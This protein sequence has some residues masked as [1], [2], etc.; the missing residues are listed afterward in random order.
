MSRPCIKCGAQNAIEA[1]FCRSCGNSF[2]ADITL[3]S[4]PTAPPQPSPLARTDSA[5]VCAKCGKENRAGTKFCRGCG[6]ALAESLPENAAQEPH[7]LA[8]PSAVPTPQKA[9]ELNFRPPNA[10]STTPSR[11]APPLLSGRQANQ[12]KTPTMIL[13][14]L[15]LIGVVGWF[16][17][18]R[19]AEK[20]STATELATH[21]QPE[22][23]ASVP[24]ATGQEE[25]P[26]PAVAAQAPAESSPPVPAGGPQTTDSDQPA[27]APAPVPVLSQADQTPAALATAAMGADPDS[28]CQ[29]WKPNVQPNES[30]K[31]M[32]G[33]SDSLAEGPGKAEWLK[34]GSLALT[35]EGTFRAGLL[36]GQGK[37]VA[38][39]GD[40]Y[41]GDYLDGK[42]ES[43]GTYVAASGE[44][45]EG[46]WHDNKREGRGVLTY[47]S[48]DRYEGDF[49]DNKREGR[50]IYTKPDGERYEGEYR[51]DRREGQGILTRADGSRYEGLFREG[52]ALDASKVVALCEANECKTSSGTTADAG[53]QIAPP[54][55]AQLDPQ[56]FGMWRPQNGD[57]TLI[58]SSSKMV[59]TF[60][61]EADSTE[62]ARMMTVEYRWSNSD[63]SEE[64]FGLSNKRT[65]PAAIRKRYEEAV[66]Q[67]EKDPTDFGIS[68]PQSSR[69]AIAAISPGVY[70]VMWSYAGGDCGYSEYI[71]DGGRMLEFSECKYWFGVTLYNRIQ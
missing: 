53:G 65:S 30:V 36:Q 63:W 59:S 23:V 27:L 49:R 40:R 46:E 55:F 12:W 22:S 51:N 38:V 43:R 20:S 54:A 60:L 29:I 31:W 47:A 18:L 28:G 57:S 35:Y 50:G 42:R 13:G 48:G 7:A 61:R 10:E 45:Y 2:E 37:M 1:R 68:D 56:W 58:I 44:R 6:A 17:Y 15:A 70:K 33:C 64:S 5:V 62:K 21:Q 41:D 9:V 69:A 3:S 8:R 25:A 34:D 32:G 67:F 39:G 19:F 16:G 71:L 66:T 26:A 52:K 14:G 24:Q 11:T 4:P